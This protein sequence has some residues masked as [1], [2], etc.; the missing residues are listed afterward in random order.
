MIRITPKIIRCFCF[1]ILS[2]AAVAPA[3]SQSRVVISQVYGGGGNSGAAYKNDFIELFNAG[4]TAQSVAGWS[5]QYASSTGTTWNPTPL[6]GTIQP[7]QYF[8]VQES[9]GAG[10]IVN[11]P[12][13]DVSGSIAMSATAGKV[14]LV[15][16]ASALT[17]S[18]PTGLID[19][20]GYGAANCFEG[21]APAPLLTNTTADVR[22][23]AGCTDGN[24]NGTDFTAAAPAPHNSSSSTQTCMAIQTFGP[25]TPLSL[26]E[27]N[28]GTTPFNFTVKLNIPA[29]TVVTF[30]A[31]TV[32]GTATAPSDY[33]AKTDV[34]YAIPIGLQRAMVTILVN[35]DTL[36]EDD[37]S[38][39][40][41]ISAISGALP[42]T[43]TLQAT[44]TILNDDSSNVN[45]SFS[46]SSLPAGS[47]GVTYS[48][49]LTVTNGDTCT[50][51]TSGTIPPGLRSGLDGDDQYGDAGRYA[52]FFWERLASP[53]ARSCANGSVS[54][55]YSVDVSFGCE[56]GVK[57]STAIHTIQGSG[58][59]SAMTGQTVE[60]EGIVVGDFQP[61]TS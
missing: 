18:C 28:S 13:P 48:Q 21:A 39:S 1:G 53:S 25:L 41:M 40:V 56:S 15:S 4:D 2:L 44:G 10:G 11:L 57:T 52:I 3:Y 34:D 9:A 31:S 22:A 8:L 26:D 7:G 6:T 50:F 30:N 58:T 20:V 32:D 5:V 49:V 54:Q 60:V 38:F 47:E 17:G 46:P 43:P 37:E 51:S 61:S 16:S 19:L 35:G 29:K 45:L 27:G 33:I 23:G 14:A 12:A 36:V 42:I 55:G 24:A 59:V